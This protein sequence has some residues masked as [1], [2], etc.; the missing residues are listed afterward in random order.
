MNQS[1]TD[2]IV[3]LSSARGTGAIALI[4]LSGPRSVDIVG[5]FFYSYDLKPKNLST[6][7]ARYAHFGV[8][9]RNSSIIDEVVITV[10]HGPNSY[11][12]ENVVEI[13]C[14][15][16]IYIQQNI[17]QML[18]GAGARAAAPGEFTMRAFLNGKLDLSQAE[19][20]ADLIASS[21]AVSH[22][23]AMRQMRGGISEKIKLLRENLVNFA[24]LIELELDFSEEDVEFA[25]RSELLKLVG[26]IITV[27]SQ[28]VSSFELGNVIKN[29]VPVAIVGKPN[30]GKSTLLNVLLEDERAIVSEIPGTTRDV[31]E[32]ELVIEG[33]LF[34]L[35]DTAGL[36]TTEDVIEQIGVNKA[37]EVMRRSAII[38]YLFDTHE[39][40]SA[41][42]Q[43]EVSELRRVIGSSELLLV[44]NKIDVD[45]VD[46]LKDEF[47][48][49]PDTLFISAKEKQNIEALKQRL[50][51]IFDAKASGSGDTIV[52]NA[53]HAEALKNAG[54]ALEKVKE[55]LERQLPGD[56]LAL[57]IRHALSELG[58]ITG[59]VTSEDLL[60]NIF[61]RFCIGK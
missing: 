16:S 42:V 3:A 57:E 23:V 35:I 40:G 17:L 45:D 60:T 12:G 2:T 51:N 27:I 19:A 29:G 33:V 48:D 43:N 52:T 47:S 9:K 10:Y 25:D 32:D 28:L 26:R 49:Y 5:A 53:R 24:S 30:A 41:D 14:H 38:V 37:Y 59:Q 1:D 56:L 50:L 4:R 21:S 61:S 7:K 11:T 39:Y 54:R 58:N 15:G 44:G 20:V 13:A 36:R 22:E 55:G 46:S 8:L 18:I 34:R 31:I 6:L